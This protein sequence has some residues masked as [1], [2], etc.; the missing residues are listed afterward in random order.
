MIHNVN[1]KKKPNVIVL[2]I[3]A[4]PILFL[5]APL[6]QFFPVGLG[7]K[8][9]V[10]SGIFTVLIFGLLL[11]VLGSYRMKRILSAVCYL[12]AFGFLLNAHF[13]NDFN[14]TRK[15]PN[16]LIYYQDID[17][18]N[19]YWVSYDRILDDWTRGY[20]GDDPED[21]SK[22]I[23]NVSGSKYKRMYSFARKTETKDIK[24]LK[25]TLSKDTIINDVRN[26]IITIK[27]QRR[28]NQ[29][30]LYA[31]EELS[32]YSFAY[33]GKSVPKDSTGAVYGDRETKS[34]IRYTVTDNDSLE[35]SYSIQKDKKVVFTLMEYS[36]DLLN[37]PNFSIAK[38]SAG[39]MPKPF[40]V[41][42]AVALKKTIIIDSLKRE[43]VKDTINE[44]SEIK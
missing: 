30:N 21:A 17:S 12:V 4:A 8:M 28:I 5:L 26:V 25:V 20:L 13:T 9:I 10:I 42:D 37:H 34:L 27:P 44:I 11:P 35:V 14:E 3:L 41:T 38:R 31:D 36:F 19:S 16:S 23:E 6:V 7:L 40:V 18:G 32:F 29:L 15:K 33:N 39:M 1:K 2:A 43:V 24:D 22:Y